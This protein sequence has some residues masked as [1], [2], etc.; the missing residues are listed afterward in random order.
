MKGLLAFVLAIACAAAVAQVPPIQKPH[1]ELKMPLLEEVTGHAAIAPC[2]G[3]T[4]IHDIVVQDPLTLY[5]SGRVYASTECSGT[6][7][8]PSNHF[9]GCLQVLWDPTGTTYQIQSIVWRK[10]ARSSGRGVNGSR[11][12]E[13]FLNGGNA[14]G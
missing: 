2:S 12:Q 7:D 10:D 6:R 11:A 14:I 3:F 9:E 13:C 5:W 8:T 1:P 4:P